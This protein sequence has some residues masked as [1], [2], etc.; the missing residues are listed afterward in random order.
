M[1]SLNFILLSTL[2]VLFASACAQRMMT[3]RLISVISTLPMCRLQDLHRKH[4]KKSIPV[5]LLKSLGVTKYTTTSVLHHFLK[6]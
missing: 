6:P 3:V 5:G 4:S 1:K 2:L